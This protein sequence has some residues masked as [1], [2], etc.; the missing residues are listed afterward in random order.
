MNRRALLAIAAMLAAARGVAAA[1]RPARPE[2]DL[3]PLSPGDFAPLRRSLAGQP[4]LVHLW[5]LTCA[6][7]LI[8]LPRWARFVAAHPQVPIVFVQFD[9]MPVERTVAVL[10]RAGL[11][12]ARH[13]TVRGVADERLRWEIDP[14]WGGELPRTLVIAADGSAQAFSG[15]AD[16]ARLGR[17]LAQARRR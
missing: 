6:P 12:A 17:R 16:F 5:G 8:E 14:D 11:A 7:C 4:A 1:A 15:S 2:P 13:F 9:P 3:Q 10:R